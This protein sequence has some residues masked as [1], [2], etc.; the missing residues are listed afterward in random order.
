ME[1]INADEIW[2]DVKVWHSLDPEMREFDA[3]VTALVGPEAERPE[4]IGE[5]D[6]W[7]SWAVQKYRLWEASDALSADAATLGRVVDEIKAEL[8]R[9]G[10]IASAVL[11]NVLR[12]RP[13]FRGQGLLGV[14]VD[15]CLDTLQLDPTRT[16]VVVRPEP[17]VDEGGPMEHGPARDDA[18]ERLRRHYETHGFERWD[19]TAVWWR[20]VGLRSA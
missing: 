18:L 19:D 3:E 15:Q 17:Q 4:P 10:E 9:P 6:G 7:L 5:I 11:L 16:L 1:T 20:P 8:A 14:I 2:V 13:E 12:L